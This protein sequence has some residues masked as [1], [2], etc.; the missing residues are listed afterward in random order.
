MELAGRL[1]RL[2]AAIIDRLLFVVPMLIP[3]IIFSGMLKGQGSYGGGLVAV[4][5]L[6]IAAVLGVQIWLLTTKGQTVGKKVMGLSIV[7][8]SDMTNGG[9]VTNVLMRGAIGWVITA[10]PVLGVLYG[11]ADPLSIFRDD[12]RCIHDHIAGTCV[13]KIPQ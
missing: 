11:L 12:R 1:D 3:T 2:W 5:T 4:F 9:F 13:I 6:L 10:V 8:V 7:K